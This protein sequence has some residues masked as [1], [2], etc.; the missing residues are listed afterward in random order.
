[1]TDS[2]LEGDEQA[3]VAR[4]LTEA[5]SPGNNNLLSSHRCTECKQHHDSK[6]SLGCCFVQFL[7][8]A[9][10]IDARGFKKR[11]E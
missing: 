2:P 5:L 11:D 10:A 7:E 3:L 8:D 9:K 4:T 1:M 6:A